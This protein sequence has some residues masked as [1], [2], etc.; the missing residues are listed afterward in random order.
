MAVKGKAWYLSKTLWVAV[1]QGIAG[2][3]AAL[4]VANP[5]LKLVGAI[6]IIKS[7]I[8]IGLRVLTNKRLV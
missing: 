2:V 6:A 3:L 5:E 4:F 8:D 1:L 7:G